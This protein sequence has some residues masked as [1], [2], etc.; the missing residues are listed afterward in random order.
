[1]LVYRVLPYDP[2]ARLGESGHPDFV[3]QPAQ[4]VS[5]LDNPASYTT[6]YFGH[7]PE[8]AVGESFGDLASWSD[9]M[10]ETPWLPSGR[11]VLGV[12]DISDETPLLDL[13]DAANL[14]ERALRPTQVVTRVRAVS[15]A[16]ALSIF[17]EERHGARRWA[18]VRWWS[19]RR[20]HWTVFGLWNIEDGAVQHRLVEAQTL[21]RTHPAVV[22]A[23]ASLGKTWH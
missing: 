10:F 21:S 23:Q 20:P 18:G 6:W 17:R 2:A 3:Y 15:Q 22:S 14:V 9:D 4:G 5:R 13:D 1:M 8:V 12:F 11:R 7:T 19:Y 16:W